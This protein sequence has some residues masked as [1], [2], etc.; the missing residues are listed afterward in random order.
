MGEDVDRRMI[1]TAL[2]AAPLLACGE[3][4][5]PP[6][7]AMRFEVTRESLDAIGSALRSYAVRNRYK[8]EEGQVGIDRFFN[9]Q[10]ESMR[11]SI[12]AGNWDDAAV[13]THDWPYEYQ[14]HFY[15]TDTSSRPDA[16]A[17]EIGSL[18]SAIEGVRK[19]GPNFV[20]DKNMQE[21]GP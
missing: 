14:V 7:L 17:Y 6:A 12:A 5:S 3:P 4:L 8:F 13:S 18:L 11:I 9:L 10:N 15:P 2:L 21:P 1:V 20:P 16:L 19:S